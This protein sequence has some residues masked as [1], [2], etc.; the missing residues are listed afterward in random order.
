VASQRPDDLLYTDKNRELNQ[1]Q[2]F[3]GCTDAGLLRWKV[4]SEP[5]LQFSA[6]LMRDYRDADIVRFCSEHK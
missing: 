3:A 6:T 4:H 1:L 2:E 5:E